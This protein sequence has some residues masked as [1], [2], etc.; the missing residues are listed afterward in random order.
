MDERMLLK[1]EQLPEPI[2]HVLHNFQMEK[3]HFEKYPELPFVEAIV[4]EILPLNKQFA[5]QTMLL[6]SLNNKSLQ[7]F[8]SPIQLTELVELFSN[9]SEASHEV[10]MRGLIDYLLANQY[11]NEKYKENLFNDLIG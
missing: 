6:Q 11:I 4:N 10:L 7:T 8:L 2:I 1:P 5:S 3:S 9:Q